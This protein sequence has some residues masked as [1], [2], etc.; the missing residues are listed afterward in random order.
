MSI[1]TVAVPHPTAIDYSCRTCGAMAGQPC[2]WRSDAHRAQFHAP[3]ERAEAEASRKQW[4]RPAPRV[5]TQADLD[6]LLA[7]E[8]DLDD[9]GLATPPLRARQV[10]AGYRPTLPRL[11]EV[12]RCAQW[13]TGCYLAGPF[14]AGRRFR[15]GSYPSSYAA[16]HMVERSG[17]P[18]VSNGALIAAALLLGVDVRRQDD[19]PNPLIGIRA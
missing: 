1:T 6:A 7:S 15:A 2:W 12:E 13:L 18:Y 14:K 3:R 10:R 5:I 8:P 9:W 19:S 16:K 17:H 11:A 4:H